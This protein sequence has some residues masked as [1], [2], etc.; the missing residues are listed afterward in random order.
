MFSY[1]Y[2][3]VDLV[4]DLIH[5]LHHSKL[6]IQL[7][8]GSFSLFHFLVGKRQ[9]CIYNE[10]LISDSLL[11]LLLLAPLIMMLHLIQSL[12]SPFLVK[13]FILSNCLFVSR[14]VESL[15]INV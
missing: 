11:V 6:C 14:V 15:S 4:Q 7:S 8:S 9:M 12:S 2:N 3:H 5:S 1:R 13:R 10:K